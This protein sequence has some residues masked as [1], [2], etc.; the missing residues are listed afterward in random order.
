MEGREEDRTRQ[1][2]DWDPNERG[3]LSL[4]LCGEKLTWHSTE[5]ENR[6]VDS[7]TKSDFLHLFG[8][9]IIPLPKCSAHLLEEL[10]HRT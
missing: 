10:I 7:K 4:S 5:P 2:G 6:G 8:L 1:S 9:G 3:L